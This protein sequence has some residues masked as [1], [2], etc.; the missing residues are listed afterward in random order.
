M[1]FSASNKEIED[2]YIVHDVPL[3]LQEGNWDC[4]IASTKMVLQYLNSGDFEEDKFEY[5]CKQLGL[6]NSIWTIDI[7]SIFSKYEIKH[8]MCTQTLGV[9]PT[10]ENESFY[11]RSF[12]SEEKRINTLFDQAASKGIYIEK[13]S[14]EVAEILKHIKAGHVIIILVDAFILKCQEVELSTNSTDSKSDTKAHGYLETT[15]TLNI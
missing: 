8:L 14:V 13:R 2:D 12:T 5:I 11:Q 10:Y 7:A 15:F 3:I 6:H 9:N 1:A 4:G